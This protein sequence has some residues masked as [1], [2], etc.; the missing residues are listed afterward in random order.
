VQL[1]Q[2]HIRLP[3]KHRNALLVDA[4]CSP[5]GLNLGPSRP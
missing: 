2:V 3:C 4:R 5:V 1:P